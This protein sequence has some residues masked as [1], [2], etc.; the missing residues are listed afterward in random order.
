VAGNPCLSY[1]QHVVLP[2]CEKFEVERPEN[3]G[4]NK[5]V[6]PRVAFLLCCITSL[7]CTGSRVPGW[8]AYCRSLLL[9]KALI[10]MRTWRHYE[11]GHLHLFSAF[12]NLTL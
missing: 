6:L 9:V 2:W 3:N 5:W 10:D 7:C 11:R 1:V 12:F 4:G 8:G